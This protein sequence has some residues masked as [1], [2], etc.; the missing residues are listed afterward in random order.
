M[1][2]FKSQLL[3]TLNPLYANIFNTSIAHVLFAIVSV[4]IYLLIEYLVQIEP[5]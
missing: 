3:Y 5:G 1:S 2:W 4:F